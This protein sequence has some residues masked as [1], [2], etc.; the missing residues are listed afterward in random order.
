MPVSRLSQPYP[1]SL[2]IDKLELPVH[3]GVTPE[4]QAEAQHVYLWLT[5]YYPTIPDAAQQ[6]GDAYHCYDSLCQHLRAVAMAQPVA[7]IEFLLAALY[8]AAREQVPPEVKLRLRLHK[9]LP[10]SL[11]GYVVEGA[12]VEYTDL[13][14][15]VL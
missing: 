4:E 2:A 14:E 7:L 8:R 3:L 10:Q 6:D 5:L 9:P 13:P 15:G 11:V 12:S 1:F